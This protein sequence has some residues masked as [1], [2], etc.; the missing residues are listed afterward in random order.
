[1]ITNLALF[2]T[3]IGLG[4]ASLVFA[5]ACGNTAGKAAS[6]KPPT[7]E[8]YK[9]LKIGLGLIVVCFPMSVVLLL[10]IDLAKA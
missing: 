3:A 6:G 1:M 10:C 8:E 4:L 5:M 7:A 2:I 9:H